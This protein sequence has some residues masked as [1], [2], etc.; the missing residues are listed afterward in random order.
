MKRGYGWH[1]DISQN[2][3]KRNHV[4]ESYRDTF[5]FTRDHATWE[6]KV[7]NGAWL[8]TVC[9]GDSGHEQPGQWVKVEGNQ[10]VKDEATSSGFFLEKTVK[11]N[12]S[13][14]R[15]TI[16]IGKPGV[17]TNTCLNWISWK[18]AP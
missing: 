8:V 2:H 18:P 4:P 17:S 6:C 3:R 12:V 10:I 16:E 5:I 7:P 9:I 14:G 11:T 13:D 15:L 1:R